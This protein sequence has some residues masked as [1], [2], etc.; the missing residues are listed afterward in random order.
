[1]RSRRVVASIAAVVAILLM[2]IP[3]RAAAQASTETQTLTLYTAVLSLAG[4]VAVLAMFERKPPAPAGLIAIGALFGAL[5]AWLIAGRAPEEVASALR[6]RVLLIAPFYATGI[7]MLVVSLRRLV[8]DNRRPA[9]LAAAALAALTVIGPRLVAVSSPQAHN[10]AEY[11]VKPA[12]LYWTVGAA[13]VVLPVLA[14]TTLPGDWFERWW[15]AVVSRVMAPSNR[16]FAIGLVAVTAVLAI[17]FSWYCFG[18]GPI[19]SDEIAQLWHA[20]ILLSGRLALPADPNPEFFAI[21]NIID[22]P[23]W[24]SQFPVGGPAFHALGVA[25]GL[26]W[27]TNPIFIALTALNVYRFVQRAYGEPQARAAVMVFVASP[28]VLIMG[29]SHMNHV[30]T[31]WLVTLAFAAL[32]LWMQTEDARVR[33][34]SAIMIGLAIGAAATIRPLDAAIAAAVI[35][36][37]M[38]AIVARDRNRAP[39][40]LVTGAAGALPVALLLLANLLTTGAPLRFGYTVLWGPNHSLGL[41]L[42]PTGMHHTAWRALL[43]AMRYLTEVNAFTTTWAVPVLLIIALAF[44][45]APKIRRWDVLLLAFFALQLSAYAFYWHDGQFAGA[46]F[47]F[48]AVPALLILATR[49]PFLLGERDL[50]GWRRATLLLI[51]VCALATWVRPMGPFGIQGMAAELRAARSSLKRGAPRDSVMDRLPR[52]L[53][54]IQ[55][56]ASSRLVR[57]MWALGV[58]RPDAARLLRDGDACAL[59]DAVRAEERRGAVDSAGRLQRIERSVTGFGSGAGRPAAPD[60]LRKADFK[61]AISKCAAELGHDGRIA[62]FISYGPMLLR[63]R[64]DAQGRIDGQVVYVMDLAERNEVLRSRFG[65]RE[66]YRWEIPRGS[67]DS[68]PKLVPYDSVTQSGRR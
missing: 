63:N 33:V 44:A 53:V 18:G 41:H 6:V 58:S 20:R 4:C 61:A 7:W 21:D 57:R 16:A 39:S 51:P 49:V 56:H 32:P 65:D 17:G 23:V 14:L 1:M 50:G 48:S 29:G 2:Y 31:V 9:A 59:L 60:S 40:L 46:R 15:A 52:S 22:T 37:V 11:A 19:N 54:F 27:V 38:L 13:L 12:I 45:L 68:I 24:M 34:R 30:P 5:V 64:F 28:V 62:D 42:D 8:P 67:P 3:L 36:G 25:V 47:L 35:G 55:E 26:T 66:W 10:L 43:L